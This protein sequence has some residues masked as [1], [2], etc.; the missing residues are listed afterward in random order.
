[1]IDMIELEET[2]KPVNE[3]NNVE[4]TR[5]KTENIKGKKA[6]MTSKQKKTKQVRHVRWADKLDEKN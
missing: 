3:E 4:D 6:V 5:R 2:T 1:M